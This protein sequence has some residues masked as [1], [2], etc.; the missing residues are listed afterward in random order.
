MAFK[1]KSVLKTHMKKHIR[2]PVVCKLC[3]RSFETQNWLN[4]HLKY[5]NHNKTFT[6]D[7]CG[8]AIKGKNSLK[9]HLGTHRTEKNFECSVCLR[10]FRT[11]K[12]L[13]KHVKGLNHIETANIQFKCSF[14]P[15]VFTT[16][17]G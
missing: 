17:N 13:R 14:C 7:I 1:E 3:G 10:K 11:V 16:K 2:Q 9:Y 4:F 12:L 5:T 15:D 8:A 6:C